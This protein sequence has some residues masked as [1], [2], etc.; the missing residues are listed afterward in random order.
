MTKLKKNLKNLWRLAQHFLPAAPRS[1][2]GKRLALACIVTVTILLGG[3]YGIA[4]WYIHGASNQPQ[5]IGASFIPD[6]ASSL[7]LDPQQTLDAMLNELGVR[8]LRLTS[9]WS[10]AEATQGTYDFSQLDWQFA[11]A[12]KAGAKVSL[13]VGLRQP[14]WPECHAPSWVDT[15]QPSS[16]WHPQLENYITEVVKRYQNSPALESYQI[17][18]EFFLRGFGECHNFERER[19]V[20]EYNLVKKLDPD[21]KSTRLNSS[22]RLTSRMPSSA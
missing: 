19:L 17:E 4:R 11:K 22:H 14:R 3:M 13:S 1:R 20:R 10:T 18:N 7:G 2:W 8:H 12:E 6:Y 9:Y 16:Q 21:R 15:T 5:V